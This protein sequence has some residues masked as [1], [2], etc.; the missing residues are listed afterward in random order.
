MGSQNLLLGSARPAADATRSPRRP[1]LARRIGRQI[2]WLN[3][4][5]AIRR[6]RQDLAGMPPYLLR[7]IG[8]TDTEAKR[9]SGLPWR[10]VPA[11]RL[12]R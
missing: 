9:E 8:L 7:D 1:G 12:R 4:A 6:E 10:H 3:L 5:L 2:A 11:S